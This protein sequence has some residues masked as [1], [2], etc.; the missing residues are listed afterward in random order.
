[1]VGKFY[2]KHVF[3]I[4]RFSHRV[5]DDSD[6]GWGQLHCNWCNCVINYNYTIIVIVIDFNV[7]GVIVF[8]IVIDPTEPCNWSITLQLLS[9]THSRPSTFF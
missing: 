8:V 9:I 7:F 3:S 1:M 4:S 5:N 6:Q 2:F